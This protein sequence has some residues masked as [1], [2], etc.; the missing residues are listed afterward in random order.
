MFTAITARAAADLAAAGGAAGLDTTPVERVAAATRA[1]IGALWDDDDGWFRSFDVKARAPVSPLTSGGP[2][3]WWAHAATPEQTSRMLARLDDWSAAVPY[4]VASS[5]PTDA[6]FE[7][8]RYWRGPVW[9]LVN[10]MIADGLAGAGHEDRA[11]EL[12]VETLGLVE[13]SGFCEYFD[14]RTGDGIGGHGFSWTAALTLAWL[15]L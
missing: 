14:P 13:R 2:V 5:D 1:G 9:V 3:A 6:T 12:R 15:I 7:P 11:E 8:E 10:W 4:A